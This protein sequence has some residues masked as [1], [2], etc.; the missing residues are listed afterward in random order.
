MKS[1]T[2]EKKAHLR[3]RFIDGT[4]LEKECDSEDHLEHEI[5]KL[6]FLFQEIKKMKEAKDE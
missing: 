2:Q 3:V 1:D 6:Y 5:S 4:V